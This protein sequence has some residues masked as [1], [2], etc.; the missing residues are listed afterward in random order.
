MEQQYK[1]L[2][3]KTEPLWGTLQDRTICVCEIP[4]LMR[5]DITEKDLMPYL[6]RPAVLEDFELVAV[7]VRWSG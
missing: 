3:H 6:E 4:D 2:K 5:N 7:R 1:A